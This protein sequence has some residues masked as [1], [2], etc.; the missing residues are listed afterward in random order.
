LENQQ[1]QI[2]QAF[3]YISLLEQLIED[4]VSNKNL[5]KK[6]QEDEKKLSRLYSIL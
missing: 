4:N 5:A 1:N 6:L 3:Q 2:K